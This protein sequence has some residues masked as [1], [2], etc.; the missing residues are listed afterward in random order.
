MDDA[1]PFFA[2]AALGCSLALVIWIAGRVWLR[3]K[4]LEQVTPPSSGA[5]G[6]IG[7]SDL[8]EILTRI[9]ARLGRLEQCVDVTALEVERVAEAQR[10]AN[11]NLRSRIAGVADS[12]SASGGGE[13]PIKPDR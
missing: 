12:W 7:A 13:Q 1:L 4:E 2:M 10:F 11:A 3:A 6:A 9:D 8:A 5:M